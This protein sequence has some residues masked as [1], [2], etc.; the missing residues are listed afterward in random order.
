MRTVVIS[1][2]IFS[3]AA[4]AQEVQLVP[5]DPASVGAWAQVVQALRLYPTPTNPLRFDGPTLSLR[6]FGEIVLGQA[7]Y[8]LLL[9]VSPQNAVGLWLDLNRDGRLTPDEELPKARLP[10]AVRWTVTLLSEPGSAPSF[11]Y[12]LQ[13][14]W[15]EGRS[16]VFVVGGAPRL[17]QFQGRPVVLVDGDL[18]GA[19]G[20]KGDFLGVD[21][22]ED[23]VIYA[24]PDGHERFK[25]SEPFT[26]ERTSY[27]VRQ[28]SPDG[29]FV[30]L[31]Q[32]AYV[33]QKVPLIPGAPAPDFS[34][35]NFLDGRA[36]SLSSFRGKVVLL[37]FW[38][39]WCPPC[40]ASLPSVRALYEE[41]H[42]QGFEIVGVSLDESEEDLRR[43]LTTYHITW[44]NAFFG[45]RWD[46]PVANL[47]RVYQ[48]PT[49][50]L[51]DK[52][53]VIRFRDVHGQELRAAVQALLVEPFEPAGRQASS[54]PLAFF[55]PDQVRLNH[56]GV[57]RFSVEVANE[58]AFPVEEVEIGW[59]GLPVG[60]KKDEAARFSLAP[61]ERKTLELVLAA[62]N[63]DP[64][65]FP[66]DVLLVVSYRYGEGN[67]PAERAVLRVPLRVLLAE[68]PGQAGAL[69]WWVL[70]LV[71]LG[72]ALAVLIL[73]KGSLFLFPLML[74]AFVLRLGGWLAQV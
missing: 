66:R 44:P 35:R 7:R 31:E 33:P 74:S 54:A 47:Y 41:F 38:A 1:L 52:R 18:D 20:T 21:V 13:V 71:V 49:T 45:S 22:D 16:Y 73:G 26:L 40:M 25:P 69:P 3:V 2:F 8:P 55:P 23:G 39:T 64:N 56:Q 9:G 42:P 5:V 28:I 36:L 72:L 59:D 32:T 17:G 4:L 65:A 67:S 68:E 29:T 6:L 15:P 43:V 12:P 10:E 46:N 62:E 57:T 34:F 60:I 70:G 53:G 48:I 27:L 58:S 11:P 50:Y 30:A 37:D 14:L 63:V 61:G 24:E 51:L 19:F